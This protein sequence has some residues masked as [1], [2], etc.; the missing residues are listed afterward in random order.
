[1][2]EV[3]NRLFGASV[4]C[5]GLLAGRDLLEAARAVGADVTLYPRDCLNIDGRLLDDV[6]QE[7]L[8]RALE[9]PILASRYVVEELNEAAAATPAPCRRSQRSRLALVTA[10]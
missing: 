9:T 3:E 1:V 5:A 7:E 8:A 6:S 2:V 4:T 10:G